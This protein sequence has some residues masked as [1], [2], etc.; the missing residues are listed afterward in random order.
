[1]CHH[2]LVTNHSTTLVNN[3]NYLSRV[4]GSNQLINNCAT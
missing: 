1:M 2:R 4:K 3:Y